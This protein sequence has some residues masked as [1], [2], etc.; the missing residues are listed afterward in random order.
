M[1]PLSIELHGPDG[2]AQ[3]A[4]VFF[5][6]Y[7]ET[8]DSF[9]DFVEGVEKLLGRKWDRFQGKKAAPKEGFV[10]APAAK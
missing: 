10:V 2:T 5:Y 8:S 4:P 7:D 3:R 1:L 6:G 9:V